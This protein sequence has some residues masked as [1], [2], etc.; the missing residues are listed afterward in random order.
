MRAIL[1]NLDLSN[2]NLRNAN[3][4][5]AY[6]VKTNFRGSDLSGANLTDAILI[7]CDFSNTMMMDVNL[8]HS[9]LTNARLFNADLTRANLTNA[10]LDGANLTAAFLFM[11]IMDGVSAIETDFTGVRM[12]RYLRAFDAN[13]SFAINLPDFP[14]N[15]PSDGAFI[16]WKAYVLSGDETAP[17]KSVILIKLEIPEDAKRLSSISR[18]CRCDK[19][20]VLG[21]YDLEGNEITELEE[22]V[23]NKYGTN[24]VYHKGEYVYPDS[25]DENRW[26]ECSNGIHFFID[27]LDAMRYI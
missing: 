18:K 9:D 21:F 15:C 5:D 3:L 7:S 24:T 19:A 14:I 2:V 17:C 6:I 10:K 13:L 8:R 11:T 23:N 4:K 26:N 16:G 1:S 12:M 22:V 25:F 20:K 27:K